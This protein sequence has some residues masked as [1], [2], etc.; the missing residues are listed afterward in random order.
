MKYVTFLKASPRAHNASE[1][2]SWIYLMV[3]VQI[4]CFLQI[5][6]LIGNF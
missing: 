5:V 2:R 1:T 6:D 4:L 3:V